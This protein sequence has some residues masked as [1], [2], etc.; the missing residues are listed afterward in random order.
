M[1][2]IIENCPCKR[3]QCERHGHCTECREHHLLKKKYLPACERL[4]AKEE[5]VKQGNKEADKT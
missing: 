1:E 3:V 2:Y 5:H 4:K